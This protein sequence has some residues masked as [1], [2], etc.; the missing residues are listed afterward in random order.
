M[1]TGVN[2]VASFNEPIQAS[3]GNIVITKSPSGPAFATIPVTDPQVSISGSTLTINP[4]ANLALGTTYY[5]EIAPGAIQDVSGND[6]SG[7]SGTSLWAFTTAL[8]TTVVINK[9][10]NSGLA[11]GVGDRI[12]LLVVG[13]EVPGSKLDMR[14]MILKDFSANGADDSGGTYQ[15]ASTA[16]WSEISIGTL[17]VIEIGTSNS[18]DIDPVDFVLS[19]GASNA[20]YFTKTSVDDSNFGATDLVMIKASG[21]TAGTTGGIHAFAMGNPSA[22]FTGFGGSKLNAATSVGTDQV[23]LAINST[24]T[25]ADY[26]G[27]GATGGVL[28]VSVTFGAQNNASN[29][30]YISQLR[31]G[32]STDYS[33][34]INSYFNNVT[35]PLIVGFGADPDKDGVP[36]GVE[37]LT[38]GNP[39][40]PGI[41]APAGL[42][43]TG[44]VFT[45]LYPQDK[46]PPTGVTAAYEWSTDMVNWQVGGGS[47]GG[48]TVTLG[49]A[50]VDAT[51]PEV[52]IYQ[53]TATVTVG[54][55]SNLFVRV[56]AKN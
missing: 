47:F 48:V 12:E 9:V 46:T 54:T 16:F 8:P 52:A 30:V 1:A 11:N 42:T 28:A 51:G 39:N 25:L 18:P 35:D 32:G 38:G 31:G 56:V 17:I 23:A 19:L 5:V 21:T 3:T 40:A 43:K 53:V 22:L 45:L 2:L 55:A 7:I 26:N 50:I 29:G 34:W 10:L 20:S 4:T 14:G 24:S 41:F 36:N 6:F 15:L 13:N 37:A 33:V 49:D 44:N 27:T